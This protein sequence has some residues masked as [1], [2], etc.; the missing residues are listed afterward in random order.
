MSVERKGGKCRGVCFVSQET[1]GKGKYRGRGKRGG[2][3]GFFQYLRKRGEEGE[4]WSLGLFVDLRRGKKTQPE[5]KERSRTV[6]PRISFSWI[7]RRGKKLSLKTIFLN[8]SRWLRRG[9][10]RRKRWLNVSERKSKKRK[11]GLCSSAL[12]CYRG[13]GGKKRAIG[14][15]GGC[16]ASASP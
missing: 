6:V 5:T 11:R 7:K 2:G 8:L 9:G 12:F 1:G 4:D 3:D 15:K 10:E 14:G 13:K 16:L